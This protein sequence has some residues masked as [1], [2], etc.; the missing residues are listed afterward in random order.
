MN[1]RF[2][3]A[4]S[5]IFMHGTLYYSAVVVNWWSTGGQL[6]VNWW[7]TGG[8]LVVGSEPITPTL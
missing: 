4:S 8:Q 2:K 7:S 5:K 6:V 3:I 1:N